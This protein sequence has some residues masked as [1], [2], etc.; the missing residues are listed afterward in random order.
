MCLDKQ[1]STGCVC[2]SVSTCVH[3]MFTILQILVNTYTVQ[4]FN[5][6]LL[7][8]TIA[9]LTQKLLKEHQMSFVFQHAFF[10]GQPSLDL[11]LTIGVSCSGIGRVTC[12]KPETLRRYTSLLV[13][14]QSC[15]EEVPPLCGTCACGERELQETCSITMYV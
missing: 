11:H 13:Q 7:T 10:D 12:P 2:T 8:L 1:L 5:G 3:C 9:Q 6:I 15:L 4:C 14:A